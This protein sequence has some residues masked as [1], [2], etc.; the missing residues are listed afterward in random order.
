MEIPKYF[1]TRFSKFPYGFCKGYNAQHCP[2]A[3]IGKWQTFV[4][5]WSVLEALL[6]DL[7]KVFDY[8]PHDSKIVKLAAH[9]FEANSL[10]LIYNYLYNWKHRV[11]FNKAYSIWKNIFYGVLQDFTL[12]PLLFNI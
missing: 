11:K 5:N 10:D 2:L 4:V 1:Q 8:I 9:G 7:S 3:I 12:G 6:T